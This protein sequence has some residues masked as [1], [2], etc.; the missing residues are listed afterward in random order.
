[1]VESAVIMC[2][3]II[4]VYRHFNGACSLESGSS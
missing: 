2:S 1:M 4:G 3:V